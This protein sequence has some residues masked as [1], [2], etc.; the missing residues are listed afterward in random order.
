MVITNVRVH[1]ASHLT[2]L[3]HLLILTALAS[4]FILATVRAGFAG[5]LVPG[6]DENTEVIIKGKVLEPKAFSFRGLDCLS[7]ESRGRTIF[8]IT[9]PDWYLKRLNLT[10]SPGTPLQVVGSKFYGNDG[11]IYIMARSL[12]TLPSGRSIQF[13]DT[14]CRPVWAKEKNRK[15]SCMKIFYSPNSL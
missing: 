5:G 3:T 11:A 4:A 7:L 13:R 8:V 10:L 1:E 12:K 15:S 9:A 6:Y 14:K 2:I